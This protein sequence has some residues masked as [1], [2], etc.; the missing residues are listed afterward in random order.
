VRNDVNETPRTE[1]ALADVLEKMEIVGAKDVLFALHRNPENNTTAAECLVQVTNVVKGFCRDAAA[2][3]ITVHLR[4]SPHRRVAS[5]TD[6][7]RWTSEIV[8]EPNFK[9]APSLAAQQIKR[10][11]D[12]AGVA[13]DIKEFAAD[14]WLVAAARKDA[15]GE[16]VSLHDPVA[17]LGGAEPAVEAIRRKGVRIVYDALYPDVDAEYRDARIFEDKQEGE[18][19]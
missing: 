17:S 12:M 11:G 19:R 8:K 15:N 9:P 7:A 3:G 1:R 6:M 4:Q 5:L 14:V 10:N 2:R 16:T 13:K 18:S